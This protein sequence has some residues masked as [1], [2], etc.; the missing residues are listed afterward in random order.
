MIELHQ[1]LYGGN[2]FDDLKENIRRGNH[3][4]MYR[5]P[6]NLYEH[7]D[8]K[9]TAS[10]SLEGYPPSYF[11]ISEFW[12]AKTDIRFDIARYLKDEISG[13][14]M[15]KLEETSII[16]ADLGTQIDLM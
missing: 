12:N 11:L 7:L 8:S 9:T 13:N 1:I 10:K 14:R 6:D 5:L 2:K 16:P 3:Y 4:L 15:G